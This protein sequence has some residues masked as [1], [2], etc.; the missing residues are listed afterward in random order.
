MAKRNRVLVS[1]TNKM[2]FA[3]GDGCHQLSNNLL[4]VFQFYENVYERSP[5]RGVNQ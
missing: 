1:M 3:V 5:G 2:E 4:M